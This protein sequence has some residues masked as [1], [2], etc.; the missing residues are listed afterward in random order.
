MN[1]HLFELLMA[2]YA[3]VT[4]VF[5]WLDRKIEKLRLNHVA[6]LEQDVDDLREHLGLERKYS[7]PDQDS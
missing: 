2:A 7:S 4:G 3:Y 6:H 1:D 5:L